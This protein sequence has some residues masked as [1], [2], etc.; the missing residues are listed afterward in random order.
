MFLNL[1]ATQ[2]GL[3]GLKNVCEGLKANQSLL[4]LDVSNNSLGPNVSRYFPP[5]I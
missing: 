1:S 2:I 3:I 4:T 5:L